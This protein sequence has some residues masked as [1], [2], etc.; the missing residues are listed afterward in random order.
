MA[1]VVLA[2]NEEVQLSVQCLLD[3]SAF[4]PTFLFGLDLG[5]ATLFHLFGKGGV[6]WTLGGFNLDL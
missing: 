3:I 2:K 1:Y 6:G 5:D 4:S